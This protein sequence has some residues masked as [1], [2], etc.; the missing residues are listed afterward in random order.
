ME[1]PIVYFFNAKIHLKGCDGM[2][3]KKGM[4]HAHYSYEEKLR[5]VNSEKDNDTPV[6][7]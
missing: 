2:A 4:S 1:N 5:I 6:Q 3:G 7:P